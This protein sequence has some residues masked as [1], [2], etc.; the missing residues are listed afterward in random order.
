M[1]V[2]DDGI[3]LPKDYGERGHGFASMRSNAERLGGRLMVEET[4]LMGG[5]TVTCLVPRHHDG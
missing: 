3:G 4:G 1:S 5:A 2:S